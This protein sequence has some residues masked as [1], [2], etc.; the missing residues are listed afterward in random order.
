MEE[1]FATVD[2]EVPTIH[3]TVYITTTTTTTTRITR[4]EEETDYR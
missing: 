1:K 3:L 2:W 4:T